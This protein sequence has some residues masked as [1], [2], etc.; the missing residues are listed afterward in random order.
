MKLK[1]THREIVIATGNPG[2]LRE[3]AQVLSGL[4]V[5]VIGLNA[6]ADIA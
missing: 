3:I 2:K 6:I 5:N 1:S 4:P